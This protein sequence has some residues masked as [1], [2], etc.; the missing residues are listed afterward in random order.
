MAPAPLVSCAAAGV[1]TNASM[2]AASADE[3]LG[4][5]TKGRRV[6]GVTPR[7]RRCGQVL[8]GRSCSR[9]GSALAA[10]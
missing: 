8:A 1:P 10:G 4:R 9:T 6:T 2:T 7:A 3:N 5:N